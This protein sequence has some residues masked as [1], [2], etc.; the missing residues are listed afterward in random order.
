MSVYNDRR[1]QELQVRQQEL[2]ELLESNPNS[3]HLLVE[4]KLVSEALVAWA[5]KSLSADL[6][7]HVQSQ[8]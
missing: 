7:R 8:L 4:L 1:H 5:V 6:Y 2:L 3:A